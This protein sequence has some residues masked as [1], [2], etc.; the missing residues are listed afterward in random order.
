V[1]SLRLAWLAQ[2]RGAPIARPANDVAHGQSFDS[3]VRT[4]MKAMVL[5]GLA[6]VASHMPETSVC[7][8]HQSRNMFIQR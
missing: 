4:E 2:P 6:Q 5:E 1:S 3:E 8:S 7:P